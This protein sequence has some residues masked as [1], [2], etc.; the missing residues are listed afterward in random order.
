MVPPFVQGLKRPILSVLPVILLLLATA[1]S[2]S[3]TVPSPAPA[4]LLTE[5]TIVAGPTLASPVD[6][7][8]EGAQADSAARPPQ[9]QDSHVDFQ[10]FSIEQGLSQS[11]VP[12]ILQDSRGF[13]W[14]GT[15]DGLNRFDG[16]EFVV[17]KH[18][19][20][21]PDSLGGNFVQ[22]LNEDTSGTLWIGTNGGGISQLDR[23]TG[24]FTHYRHDPDDP[25]SLSDN[26]VLALYEDR[27][28]VLWI[29]TA[30]EGLDSFDP[31]TGQSVHHQNDPDN[32]A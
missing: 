23:E 25:H 1:C 15:Q 8:G 16:Y 22:A 21:D 11:V 9:H 2:S 19:P 20:E 14:F 7:L 12:S 29:G 10:H 13:M 27:E 32:P 4:S 18:D 3:Q 6:R 17:Y 26:V 24:R 5:T 30:G 31:N 28:G